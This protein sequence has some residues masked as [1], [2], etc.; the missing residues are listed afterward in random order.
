VGLSQKPDQRIEEA[1]VGVADVVGRIVHRSA[2]FPSRVPAHFYEHNFHVVD[3]QGWKP[4]KPTHDVV[5]G[6]VPGLVQS[7]LE[8]RTYKWDLSNTAV[9]PQIPLLGGWPV[10]QFPKVGG[11]IVLLSSP[12]HL[13]FFKHEIFFVASK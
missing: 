12:G 2:R 6:P 13:F 8:V 5:H 10:E 3:R 9:S 7:P 11:A 4:G 1:L